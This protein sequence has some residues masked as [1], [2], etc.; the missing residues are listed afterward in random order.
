MKNSILLLFFISLLTL[1]KS[2]AQETFPRNDVKDDRTGTIAFTNATIFVN[3]TTRIEGGTLLVR[4]GKVEKS[5]KGLA[6]PAGYTVIDLKGKY[7][8]PS[9]IDLHTSYGLPKVETPAGGGGFG[10]GAEQIQTKTK[11]PYNDNQA[12]KPEYN[13]IAEFGQDSKTAEK[14]RAAGFGT[15]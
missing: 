10:A 14:F 2:F 12:V 3:A 9:F 15:V 6:V 7:I 1:E 4:D 11:G 5:G 13:A 8:Y